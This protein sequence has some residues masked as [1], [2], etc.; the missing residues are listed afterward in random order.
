M[1][2]AFD[3]EVHV[4]GVA[5][6]RDHEQRAEAA[7]DEEPDRDRHVDRD[8]A[9]DQPQHEPGRDHAEVDDRDVLQPAEY[10]V[11]KTM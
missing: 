10:V 7:D 11:V 8:R 5:L 2:G 3:A 9:G 1:A 6:A 4:L